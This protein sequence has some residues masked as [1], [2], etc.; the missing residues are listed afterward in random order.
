MT[1]IVTISTT[2]PVVVISE[3]IVDEGRERHHNGVD[4]IEAGASMDLIVHA[5]QSLRIVEVD[6]AAEKATQDVA[7]A[8]N[9]EASAKADAKTAAVGAIPTE[10]DAA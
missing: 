6:L 3:R 4:R 2:A 1:A 7:D 10:G 9:A 5:G 8:A